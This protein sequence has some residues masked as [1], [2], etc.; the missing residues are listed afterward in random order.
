MICV[1]L[2]CIVLYG[3]CAA[4]LCFAEMFCLVVF[5]C[6]VLIVVMRR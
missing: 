6:T 1:A 5:N 4:L 2:D 3:T